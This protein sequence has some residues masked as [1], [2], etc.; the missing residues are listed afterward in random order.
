MVL[1]VFPAGV[2]AT[3]MDYVEIESVDYDHVSTALVVAEPEADGYLH[4]REDRFLAGDRFFYLEPCVEIPSEAT[5][6]ENFE[7]NSV[8]IVLN[9]A[10]TRED[11]AFTAS[12]FRD[13]GAVYVRD[14]MYLNEHQSTYAQQLWDAE[15]NVAI[16]ERNIS[17]VEQVRHEAYQAHY[18]TFQAYFDVCQEYYEVRQ[19]YYEARQEYYEA[20]QNAE[21]SYP[22]VNFDEFR[23][24]LLVR[25]DQNCGENVLRVV[26]ELQQRE[27]IRSVSP[28]HLAESASIVNPND[29]YFR[30]S[31]ND[32][33]HQW[34]VNRL[35]L[36]Q[37]WG[38]T[39]GAS[40]IR[41][42]ILGS[43]IDANHPELR[44]RVREDLGGVFS[45][46]AALQTLID[47]DGALSKQALLARWG[48]ME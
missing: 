15:R 20:R 16:S 29:H 39:T 21:E 17:E 7:D 5:L 12:D 4:S 24:I 9:R 27:Y 48:T 32:V 33:N 8:I 42:G 25:L 11:R 23:Q 22:M 1:S 46:M 13:V 47:I 40:E 19:E 45:T 28:N 41:V 44:G 36:P 3:P 38:I 34:A 35:S 10:A 14:I 2:F 30:L 37:A 26:R 6:D 43:R 18:E 31:A